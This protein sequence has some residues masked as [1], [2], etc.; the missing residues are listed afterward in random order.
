M[1]ERNYYGGAPLDKRSF[2]ESAIIISGQSTDIHGILCRPVGPPQKAILFLPG[3]VGYR[4]GPSRLFVCMARELAACGILSVRIDFTGRGFCA[5][6]PEET[7]IDMMIDDTLDTVRLIRNEFALPAVSVCGIC[8]G[9]NTALGAASLDHS[10]PNVF[11][12]STLAFSNAGSPRQRIQ[13]K[14]NLLVLYARKALQLRTWRRIVRGDVNTGMVLETISGQQTDRS[15]CKDSKRD[16]PQELKGFPG[17][18]FFIYGRLDTDAQHAS[19]YYQSPLFSTLNTEF[20]HIQNCGHNFTNPMAQSTLTN[21]IKKG[22]T[23]TR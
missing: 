1:S 7:T 15:G 6:K 16:I 18:I 13:K 4:I 14:I 20:L 5:G 8:S 12:L 21:F 19:A 17:K 9:G 22:L 23:L 2:T 10:V 11:A 3:W